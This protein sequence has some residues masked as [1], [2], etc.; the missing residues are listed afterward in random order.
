VAASFEEAEGDEVGGVAEPVGQAG[1]QPQFC[2]DRLGEPVGQAVGD[3]GDDPGPVLAD[4]MVELRTQRYGTDGFHYLAK[5]RVA[6]SNPVVRSTRKC[7]STGVG[8]PSPLLGGSRSCCACPPRALGGGLTPME[9]D[10]TTPGWVLVLIAGTLCSI[11]AVPLSFWLYLRG[12]R[13]PKPVWTVRSNA[14]VGV[15]LFWG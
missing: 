14:V 11:V 3:R 5:V 6:G 7:R 4:A 12:R 15:R 2:V 10:P 8:R 1:E 9:I 13:S